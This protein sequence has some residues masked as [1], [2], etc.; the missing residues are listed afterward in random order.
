M[1]T[2]RW[3][4]NRL[5]KPTR[6][7][8]TPV[9][10]LSKELPDLS[11]LYTFGCLCLVT[12]PGPLREGDQ[13]FMDRGAPGLYLGPSEEGLCHIVYV[14][15]L[16]RV[17]PTAKLRVWEDQFPGLRGLRY[18][19]FPSLPA[20]SSEGPVPSDPSSDNTT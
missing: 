17:L 20:V 7:N 8:Q 2:A 1:Q 4:E 9:Y 18:E 5:P 14:F 6:G 3:I 15:A 10:M 19:W 11:Y 12:L 13:H 16:R